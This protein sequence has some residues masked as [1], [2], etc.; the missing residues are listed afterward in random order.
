MREIKLHKDYTYLEFDT[1]I[2]MYAELSKR[3]SQGYKITD[4][5]FLSVELKKNEDT[6]LLNYLPV[7]KAD[8]GIKEVLR[9][10]YCPYELVYPDYTDTFL[11]VISEIKENFGYASSYPVT[12]PVFDKKYSK[13]IILLLDGLGENILR[14][15]LSENS[16][17]RKHFSHSIHAVYPSTTAAATTAIKSGRPP[18]ATGWTGWENYLREIRKNVVLFTGMDYY[19]EES[20]GVSVYDY[21]PYS[22]FY[23][24]MNVKGYCIEPD[25]S[26]S[27]MD[28]SDLLKRSLAVNKKEEC[29]I[30]YVYCT[31]P[32][33][34]MHKYGAYSPEAKE[35]CRTLDKAVEE[36]AAELEE[37]T[38]LLITADH[39]HTNVRPLNL[40]ACEPIMELLERKPSN[41]ARCITF[42]VSPEKR[43]EFES[44]F[45]GLFS[46]VYRLYKTEEAIKLGF[47]GLP[48]E[49]LNPRCRDFLA[50]YVAV[51]IHGYYF[52]YKSADDYIFKSHHAGITKDEM[53][54]PICIV[55][56]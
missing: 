6:V 42:K 36:Y 14:R 3:L 8:E 20:T 34:T 29:S 55:R 31:E 1:D 22:M 50:D 5:V 53:L 35:I 38:L 13:V 9:Q 45:N 26:K 43:K 7:G 39:G 33:S 19:S 40:Y 37:D 49:K 28:I 16:F 12:R 41:D 27:G 11:N 56:R 51:G 25:F 18:S 24:D 23:E 54:V 32:D 2:S 52:N 21:L 17:L 44:R 4:T 48:E 47:F 46:K 10:K 15:N 30:Q